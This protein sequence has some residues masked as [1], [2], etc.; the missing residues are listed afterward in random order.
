MTTVSF[1]HQGTIYLSEA[2]RQGGDTKKRPVLVVSIDVRNQYSSTLL[3]V[4]FS[5]DVD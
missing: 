2:L 1:P 3:V 5:S 4:P